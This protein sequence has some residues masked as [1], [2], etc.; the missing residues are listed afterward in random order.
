MSHGDEKAQRRA[1]WLTENDIDRGKL[2]VATGEG[3]YTYP[4]HK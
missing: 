4:A 1:A 2:G 3:F